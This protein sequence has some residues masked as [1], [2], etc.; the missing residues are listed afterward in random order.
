MNDRP[1]RLGQNSAWTSG[2]GSPAVSVGHARDLYFGVGKQEPDP[3]GPVCVGVPTLPP[4]V[5]ERT[6]LLG[7]LGKVAPTG[8]TWRALHGLPGFGKSVLAA[9][10]AEQVR[11]D[12]TELSDVAWLDCT[13]PTT[14][15][16]S[17]RQVARA[18]TMDTH[19]GAAPWVND[20]SHDGLELWFR[21]WCAARERPLLVIVD[22]WDVLNVD[23]RSLFVGSSHDHSTRVIV[24]TT[25]RNVAATVDPHPVNVGLLDRSDSVGVLESARTDG[26]EDPRGVL[27]EL[28][29]LLGDVSL[30]IGLAASWARTHRHSP[31]H[32]LVDALAENPTELLDQR[33][34]DYHRTVTGLW[35]AIAPNLSGETRKVLDELVYIRT[36]SINLSRLGYDDPAVLEELE[37][38]TSCSITYQEGDA[39]G[40]LH[41]LLGTAIRA[42][43]TSE[44][45]DQI[46][47]RLLERTAMRLGDDGSDHSKW[48]LA[49][50]IDPW[51]DSLPTPQ[52]TRPWA[53]AWVV[54]H[55][56]LTEYHLAGVQ[57]LG[58]ARQLI[59][60][61]TPFNWAQ[62]HPDTLNTRNNV[63]SWAGRAGNVTEARRLYEELLSDGIRVL[64]PDHPDTLSSR[65]S[66]AYW[67]G[68]AGNVTEARRLYEELLSDRI[69]VL[70]PDHPD[71]LTTRGNVAYWVGK[72]GGI[73]EAQQIFKELLPDRQRVLGAE[74]PSTLNTRNSIAYW[75]GKAGNIAE[76]RQV[77]G[78]LLIDRLRVLG[79]DHPDTLSTRGSVAYWTGQ[80][81]GVSEAC[82]L[83]KELLTDQQ[84]VLGTDHPQTL[85]TRYDVAHWTYEAGSITEARWLFRELLVDQQRVLG[86]DHPDT[87]ITRR[88][89]SRLA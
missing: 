33:L 44:D 8:V 43:H 29:G 76:A 48:P 62:D 61:T 70:G 63:A 3:L 88:A 35:T 66:V 36:A 86:P 34:G 25:S 87:L 79:P 17:I 42:M 45:A 84:R 16:E 57:N 20:E 6:G 81:G 15:G 38:S 89:N 37:G 14:L 69:R 68:K 30:G 78:N 4:V 65:A 73:T 41:Q 58:R 46:I 40:V 26:Y 85:S 47:L 83:S 27:D 53:K 60:R 5:A 12:S 50:A 64:G 18:V 82:R 56:R 7:Q 10:L 49:R 75:A 80:A 32:L 52:P 13:N 39:I 54:I 21:T 77:F 23:P 9:L 31:L 22:G 72:A 51:I 71:T 19:R 2:P 74:H 11:V 55:N 67:V 1:D 24:T 28:C 59:D